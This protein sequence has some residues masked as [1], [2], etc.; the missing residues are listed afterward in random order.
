MPTVQKMLFPME[1][2]EITE[3]IAPWVNL[4]AQRFEASVHVLHVIPDPGYWGVAYGIS[5]SHLD[6]E[7]GLIRKA[8][9]KVD[10]FCKEYMA[11]DLDLTI[12]TVLGEP[13]EEILRYIGDQSI[14]LVVIGTHGRRGFEKFVFGS[15]ADRV[16]KSSPVPVLTVNPHTK[17]A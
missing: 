9:E 3:K 16:V 10:A 4:A 11:K 5:P 13:S 14:S 7:P 1:L 12:K 6:D 15:V 8:Q 17:N 2:T